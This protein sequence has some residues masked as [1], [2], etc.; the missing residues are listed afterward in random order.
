MSGYPILQIHVLAILCADDDGAN[1]KA[2]K[3]DPKAFE[4]F[5]QEVNAHYLSSGI[6]FL[7]NFHIDVIKKDKSLL[8]QDFTVPSNRNLNAAKSPMTADEIDKSKVKHKKARNAYA[9]KRSGHLVVFFRSGTNLKYNR[10]KGLWEIKPSSIA[11]SGK[12]NEF[13]AMKN[14]TEAIL[15]AHEAGHYFHLSHTHSDKAKLTDTEKN[16][17]PDWKNKVSDRHA[18]RDLVVKKVKKAIKAYVDKGHPP[19]KGHFAFDG[20]SSTVK[21]TPPD[22]RPGIFAYHGLTA[23]AKSIKIRV[24]LS[25]GSRY[26]TLSPDKSNIMSYFFREPGVKRFSGQQMARMRNALEAAKPPS[27]YLSRRHLISRPLPK[28]PVDILAKLKWG[29]N[30]THF[31]PYSFLSGHPY[32][33]GYSNKSSI[34]HFDKIDEDGRGVEILAKDTWPK[35]THVESFSIGDSRYLLSY[36]MSNG[37]VRFDK[38]RLDGSGHDNIKTGKWATG[39]THVVP[40]G[41]NSYNPDHLLVYNAKTGA[42]RIDRFDKEGKGSSNLWKGKWG[43][44]WSHIMSYR[45]YGTSWRYIIY[46]ETTGLAHFDHLDNVRKGPKTLFKRNWSPGWTHFMSYPIA[47]FDSWATAKFLAYNSVT[48]AA[49][50]NEVSDKGVTLGKKSKWAAGWSAFVP[51]FLTGTYDCSEG[52]IAYNKESGACHFDRLL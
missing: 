24:P 9:K 23:N 29:P 38:L 26:Y 46:N 30:W 8:N 37:A 3:I 19:E 13:I 48:G 2:Q 50:F 12:T 27:K 4:V 44:G 22:P 1:N 40:I 25:T 47:V 18:R 45:I 35:W 33:I 6:K 39:W 10:D 28:H 32:L 52:F 15:F 34:V 51:T 36:N 14:K 43:T 20:D 7:F 42:V 41:V 21:D 11:F 49:H 16:R 31:V 5:F 17:Y